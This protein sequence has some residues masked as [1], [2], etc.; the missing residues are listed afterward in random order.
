MEQNSR[1]RLDG[2]VPLMLKV[3]RGDK[4]AFS[5]LYRKY[6]PLVIS[7]IVKING[8][9][10]S[11]EDLAQEVFIRIWQN[12]IKYRPNA[13]VKT[14]LFS[15][16]RKVVHENQSKIA[17]EAFL[18]SGDFSYLAS[19]RFQSRAATKGN[20]CVQSVKKVIASLPDRQRQ[21]CELVYISC[22]TPVKAAKI[23]QCSVQTI[24]RNLNRARK[25][26]RKLTFSL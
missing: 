21:A 2:D 19:S 7:Y 17:R 13:T 10:D 26:L 23:L 18:D 1:T 14:Y 9:Y 5:R 6:F 15:Y 20:D 8:Q 4:A 24:Y 11:S 3:I 12:R 16:A 25:K 22:F